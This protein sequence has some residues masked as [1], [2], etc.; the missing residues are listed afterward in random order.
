MNKTLLVVL[1][2]VSVVVLGA[3]GGG[4]FMMW[5]KISNLQAAADEAEVAEEEEGVEEEA[6]LGTLFP[7]ETFIV[8]LADDGGKRYL[9]VTMNLEL[10]AVE[11]EEEFSRRLPQIRDVVLMVLPSKRFEDVRTVDGKMALREEIIDRL[12]QLLR[13]QSV[14]N[15]YFTEFVIQ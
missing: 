10:A 1:I 5:S 2:V 12:N 13:T 6:S 7:L 14:H 11:M 8:N 3:V 4:F 9:R 15:I